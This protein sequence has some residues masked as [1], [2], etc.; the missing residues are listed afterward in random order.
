MT[1]EQWTSFGLGVLAGA[2]VGGVV[3]LLY[4]PKSGKDT[5]AFIGE[6]VSDIKH[7]VGEKIGDMRHIAGE[8]LSGEECVKA[9]RNS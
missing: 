1:S 3:A 9:S 5:R 4:A 6:K 8:K 7:T 2:V